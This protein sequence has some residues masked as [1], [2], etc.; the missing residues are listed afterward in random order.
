MSRISPA[1]WRP[2]TILLCRSRESISL[3]DT[4]PAV[5]SAF[6]NP[7]VPLTGI[8]VPVMPSEMVCRFALDS[9]A[10]RCWA[11]MAH[12]SK[13]ASPSRRGTYWLRRLLT[14]RRPSE[15]TSAR[16]FSR[17]ESRVA[18]GTKLHVVASGAEPL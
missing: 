11:E 13:S 17:K 2:G 5:T 4:P 15:C 3:S 6:L 10:A 12:C 7:S 16:N 1:K 9:S 14:R 18:V 8:V